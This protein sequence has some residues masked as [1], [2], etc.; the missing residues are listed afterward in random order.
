MSIRKSFKKLRS[1]LDLKQYELAAALNLSTSLINC[2]EMGRRSPSRE[3][4][5]R[6]D[7]LIKEKGIENQILITEF[8]T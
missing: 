4:L 3:T 5:M 7:A 2:Y 1:L 6:V 8:L